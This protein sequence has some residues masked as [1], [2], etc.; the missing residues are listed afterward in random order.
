MRFLVTG[1]AGSLTATDDLARAVL[2]AAAGA[3]SRQV[4]RLEKSEHGRT[5][6]AVRPRG[7]RA[8]VGEVCRG[9]SFSQ[10]SPPLNAETVS[11]TDQTA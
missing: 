5:L 8:P 9:Q 10:P 1:G 11:R 3:F 2:T 4:E 7:R 6:A